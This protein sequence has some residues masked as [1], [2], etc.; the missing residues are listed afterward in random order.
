MLAFL[1]NKNSEEEIDLRTDQKRKRITLT[2]VFGVIAFI[3]FNVVMYF[4]TKV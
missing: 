2:V 1:Q 4:L 3:L